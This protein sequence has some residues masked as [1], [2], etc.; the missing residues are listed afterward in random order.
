M[1]GTRGSTEWRT[2]TVGRWEEDV[3]VERDVE[4]G[5]QQLLRD[6]KASSRVD[7]GGMTPAS[8]AVVTLLGGAAGAGTAELPTGPLGSE[9]DE[10]WYVFGTLTSLE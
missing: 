3:L 4:E 6:S 7:E 1:V 9:D 5:G 2:E 8:G 10:I